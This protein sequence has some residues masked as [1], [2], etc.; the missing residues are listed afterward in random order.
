[1]KSIRNEQRLTG[2][3]N[4][5]T[6]FE[7]RNNMLVI[8]VNGELDHHNSVFIKESADEII[9]RRGIMNII[10]DFEKTEFMDSSG[11]GVIMGRFKKVSG[12]G[13]MVGVVNVRKNVE[14][15]LL[16]SGLNKII[17]RYD[18]IKNAEMDMNGGN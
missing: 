5:K 18:S 8:H 2:T 16:Y 6:E 7:V 17:R 14:K 1:M 11:I 3:S 10:F 4:E 9:C 13:G 12:F 15:I